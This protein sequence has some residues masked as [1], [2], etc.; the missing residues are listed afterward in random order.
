LITKK[1]DIGESIVREAL[2]RNFELL[3]YDPNRHIDNETIEKAQTNQAITG[4]HDWDRAGGSDYVR[5][6]QRGFEFLFSNIKLERVSKDGQS[7]ALFT[8]QWLILKL[9]RGISSPV[10]ILERGG[11]LTINPFTL[12]NAPIE[13]IWHEVLTENASF[14]KQFEVRAIDPGIAIYILMPGFM[15]YIMSLDKLPGGVG[16]GARVF[17]FQND[18]VYFT[19]KTRRKLFETKNPKALQVNLDDEINGI[20]HILDVL[21]S[22]GNLMKLVCF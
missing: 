2:A 19:L 3:E 14:N 11:P 5:G 8:G 10:R 4:R 12:H 22:N 7:S 16:K 20:K 21:L 9:P 15:D 18:M 13:Q 1:N 17:I 6:K